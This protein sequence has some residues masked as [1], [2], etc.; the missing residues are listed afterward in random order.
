MQIR[1]N[2][3]AHNNKIR[4]DKR[5]IWEIW[6]FSYI[7]DSIRGTFIEKALSAS[8]QIFLDP[9]QIRAVTNVT[10]VFQ[11]SYKIVSHYKESLFLT[12]DE[13]F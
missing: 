7:Y 10:S 2:V 6:V 5:C 13:P 8:G 1:N 3:M 9:Y 12:A 4:L 11:I